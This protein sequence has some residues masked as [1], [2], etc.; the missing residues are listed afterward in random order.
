MVN[1]TACS[2]KGTGFY[3]QHPHGGS[4]V[5][6]NPTPPSGLGRHQ[7]YTHGSQTDIETTP[8]TH[9]LILNQMH[10][11]SEVYLAGFVSVGCGT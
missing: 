2:C 3:F 7:A 6:G 1:R 8:H 10:T 9:T 5:P 4:Q 11:E